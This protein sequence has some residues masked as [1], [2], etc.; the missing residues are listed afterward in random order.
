KVGKRAFINGDIIPFMG[1]DRELEVI[2]TRG[3]RS[4]VAIQGRY[5]RVRL[6]AGVTDAERSDTVRAVLENWFREQAR[7]YILRRTSQLADDYAFDYQKIK[8]RGQKTRWG[9]CSNKGNLN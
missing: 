2:P 1:E 6:K 5:I 7:K 9:S 3:K 8:I 4:T